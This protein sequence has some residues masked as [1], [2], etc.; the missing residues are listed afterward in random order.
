MGT[1]IYICL[2]LPVR[3]ITSH[4]FGRTVRLRKGHGAS[5]HTIHGKAAL[6]MNRI[7]GIA[8]R[9]CWIGEDDERHG[10]ISHQVEESVHY[11]TRD[12]F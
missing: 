11:F 8:G 5:R 1:M 7:L 10:G 6:L 9:G 3:A 2:R 4:L 12:A